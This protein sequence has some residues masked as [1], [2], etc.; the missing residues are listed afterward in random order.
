[1]E[2]SPSNQLYVINVVL[3]ITIAVGTVLYGFILWKLSQIFSTKAELA[4]LERTVEEQTKV[5][6]QLQIRMAK[7]D[8]PRK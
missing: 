8:T 6:I 2:T 7:S 1:M 3:S 5:I 4:K